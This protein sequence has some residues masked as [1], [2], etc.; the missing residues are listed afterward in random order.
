MNFRF[1]LGVAFADVS[2]PLVLDGCSGAASSTS[3]QMPPLAI[4]RHA[5]R[6]PGS[7]LILPQALAK[8]HRAERARSWMKPLGHPAPLLYLSDAYANV[9]NV[10]EESGNSQVPIGQIASFN[11]PQGLWVTLNQNLWVAN[12]NNL[13]LQAY[14]RGS[15]APYRTLTDPNGYPAGVCGNNNKNLVYGLDI[16]SLSDGNGQTINVYG[17]NDTSPSTVLIDSNSE[18]LYEC[19]VDSHGNLFVT[20]SNL[21]GYGEVDEF[22]RG[23]TTPVVLVSNLVY[24]IGITIDKYDALAVDDAEANGPYGDSVIYLYAP[25]YTGGPADSFTTTGS[26]I[27]T[28]LDHTQTH[29]WGADTK[30][31]VAQEW[32][33]PHGAFENETSSQGLQYPD[34]VAV[35]PAAKP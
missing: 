32:S 30:N 14:H 4:S 13:T 34:G 27:E 3:A 11:E 10:Y 7:T 9:V 20:L 26:I 24:P 1:L 8:R 25:P 5:G 18:A 15:F 12:T 33:Y 6:Q 2:V 23:S 31:L 21:L 16:L 35:S 22:P 17:K 19:A 29:L 28:A